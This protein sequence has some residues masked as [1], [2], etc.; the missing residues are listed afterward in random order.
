MQVLIL[1]CDFH[2]ILVPDIAVL[3]LLYVFKRDFFVGAMYMALVMKNHYFSS[4]QRGRKDR[5]YFGSHV[6]RRFLSASLIG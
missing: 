1:H 4:P 2:T 5:C 3:N 6:T